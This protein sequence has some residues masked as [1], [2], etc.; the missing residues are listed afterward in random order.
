MIHKGKGAPEVVEATDITKA[1]NFKNRGD[2][3]RGLTQKLAVREI[4]G[5]MR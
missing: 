4:E 2:K 3:K 1:C 5:V